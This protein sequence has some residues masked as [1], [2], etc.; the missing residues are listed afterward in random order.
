MVAAM[1]NK[2]LEQ[3][4]IWSD[5]ATFDP[6]PWR[7]LIHIITAGY[8]CQPFSNAG[9]RLGEDD[10]RH[11]WPHIYRIIRD[12]KPLWVF[13][14]NV[15]AH[16]KNGFPTV[17]ADL[18]FAGYRVEAGIYSAAEVGA[19]HLRERLFFLGQLS[20]ARSGPGSAGAERGGRT[21][22]ADLD[23][24]GA[25][26]GLGYTNSDGPPGFIFRERE[27]AAASWTSGTE[28]GNPISARLQ[29]QGHGRATCDGPDTWP[30]PAGRGEKQYEWEKPRII[31]SGVGGTTHG[32][33][34][35][36]EQLY[37]L[38]NGVVP[39]A[40]TAMAFVALWEKLN[41]L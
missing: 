27:Q 2:A 21:P 40:A 6:E 35:R 11:I 19:P 5:V 12:L 13:C 34:S 10:P 16:L 22:G 20:N 15:A 1:E 4:P 28:L 8:P 31:K 24:S 14:E 39:V 38:G 9:L 26:A 37:M 25:R 23:R 18:I 33:G 3:F 32:V 36:N 30:W 17:R 29:G 41:P 7:G